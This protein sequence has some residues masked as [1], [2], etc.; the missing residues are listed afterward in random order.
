MLCTLA[1]RRHASI[2]GACVAAS[3]ARRRANE[4]VWLQELDDAM[5]PPERW[6]HDCEKPKPSL[7]HHCS[8]C[9]RCVL[10]MDHHCPWINN[11]V[12]FG[13]YRYFFLF[14]FYMTV[15]CGWA[16]RAWLCAVRLPSAC[17]SRLPTPAQPVLRQRSTRRHRVQC[18]VFVARYGYKLLPRSWDLPAASTFPQVRAANRF[19]SLLS[20]L[21]TACILVAVGG[22]LLWHAY[23]VATAQGTVDFQRNRAAAAEA[24]SMGRPWRN[25]HDLGFKRNWQ[26]RFDERGALWALTWAMPRLRPHSGDGFNFPIDRPRVAL[27]TL[28]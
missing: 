1:L 6:C 14:L 9:R 16:V 18:P 8:V 22:M 7:S 2:A 23:L 3:I 24:A 21:L 26:Q 10:Q 4:R 13:N 28:V 17:T 5:P 27:A 19:T 15:A 25:M 20:L 12:G 11:C